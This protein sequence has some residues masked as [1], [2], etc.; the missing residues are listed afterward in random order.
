MARKSRRNTLTYET[1]PALFTGIC[2]AIRT[3]TGGTD[4][5]NHQDIPSA[6]GGISTGTDVIL[7]NKFM[8]PPSYGS[9]SE[10]ITVPANGQVTICLAKSNSV[11]AGS[12]KKNGS[13]VSPNWYTFGDNQPTQ[14]YSFSVNADDVIVISSGN[15]GG[16]SANAFLLAT[17][18]K[19]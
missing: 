18:V 11:S 5:I 17:L 4:P 9:A 6:I 10:T 13:S 3:K 1:L 7:A 2:D 12:V 8:N 16:S 14:Q 15:V 19:S